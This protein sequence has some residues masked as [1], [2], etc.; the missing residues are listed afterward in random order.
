MPRTRHPSDLHGPVL[1]LD[2]GGTN[3]RAAVVT[4]D[5]VLVARQAAPTPAES[6]VDGVIDACLDLL[7]GAQ[8]AHRAAGGPDPVAV[9][10]SA[11][12]PLSARTGTLIDPPNLGRAYWGLPLGPRIGDALG[13]PWALDKDTN[14]AV[15]GEAAFGAGQGSDDLVYLTIS[16]G[17]G[18]AALSDGR[19]IVGPDGVGGEFGHL[20]V[21]MDGP[22][23]G[24]GARG[25]LEAL[26]S[27]TGIA[28]AAREAL[29]A[30]EDAPHLARIA[31]ELAPRP[32]AAVHVS[33][34]E[35]LGDPVA[36][37]IMERAV[38]AVAAS[39]VSIVDI[40]GPDRVICGGG[41]SMALGERLLGPARRAVAET[42]F[43]VQAERARVVPAALGDDVGLIGTLALVAMALPQPAAPGDSGP[44]PG[45]EPVVAGPD[46]A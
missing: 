28:R 25:H 29:A 38:R 42:A 9:G 22:R 16:T 2:L 23:C 8:R 27:G 20:T 11:P 26:A 39:I 12:G 34:A 21:D 31:A 7:R 41:I 6:G 3:T 33:Q 4:P 40:F 24:C 30:G 46:Q 15:L 1:A 14:V 5:G 18:G 32:L 37:R 19:L 13:L 44:A 43:R 10:I 36:A 17:V 45:R 35:T